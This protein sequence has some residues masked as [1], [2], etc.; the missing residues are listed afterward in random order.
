MNQ[1]YDAIVVGAGIVGTACARAFVAEGMS[2]AVVEAGILAGGATAA[3]M[4]HIVV[5]DDSPAQFSLTQY[6]QSLWKALARELPREAEYRECGTIWVAVD[7]EEMIAVEHKH[8]FYRQHGV[9]AAILGSNELRGAEPFLRPGL[10]G[11]LMVPGDAVVYAP[12]VCRF[13]LDSAVERGT[14][15]YSERALRIASGTVTLSSGIE[16]GSSR[17]INA[18]GEW[19]DLLTPGIQL[20]RR[21]G[22]LAIT[23]R[24]PGF[25][26]HQLVE[27][28]Y[29]KSAHSTTADSV[30]FNLQPRA[31]GQV[32][33]GS[34]RQYDIS[35]K[36][37]EG[38]ILSAML[39]RAIEYMPEL[40][41]KSVLRTWTGFRA[42]TPDKLPLIG[43]W[44][45]DSTIYLATGHEGLGITT[46]L[47]TARLLADHF[48]GRKPEIAS[49][50]YLPLRQTSRVIHG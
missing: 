10:L 25:L 20:R 21:K 28:G 4:G 15:V 32:L 42:A 39:R 14:D 9:E 16:L 48:A 19:A 12:A 36:E 22:Y 29:L 26:R 23:D 46:S 1:V 24:Y 3:G 41:A 44:Q 5:M 43:P 11:G 35:S 30:A 38:A 27:L 40:A 7:E 34:S 37:V 6:S 2:V 47:G 8:D 17:I 49:E 50:P 45:E 18:T 33:I 31:T 13:L